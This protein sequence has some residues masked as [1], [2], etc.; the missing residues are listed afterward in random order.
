[1]ENLSEWPYKRQGSVERH[2]M[3][4]GHRGERVLTEAWAGGKGSSG[5]RSPDCTHPGGG[6]KALQEEVKSDLKEAQLEG[7]G[8]NA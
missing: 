7:A 6:G 4:S 8:G 5:K 3:G 2:Q 1:M